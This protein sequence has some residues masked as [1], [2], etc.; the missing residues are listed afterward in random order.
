MMKSRF[1]KEKIIATARPAD[2]GANVSGPCRHD[3]ISGASFYDWRARV[4]RHG[5]IAAATA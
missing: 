1:I 3:G 4:R 5:R 2:A